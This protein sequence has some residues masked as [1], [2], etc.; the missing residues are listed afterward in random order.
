MVTTTTPLAQIVRDHP[1]AARVFHRYHLDFCC[2]GQHSLQDACA[3][4][5]IDAVNV[6]AEL[7]ATIGSD[8]FASIHPDMWSTEFLTNFILQN[9]HAFVRLELPQ[10]IEQMGKVVQKHGAKFVEAVAIL[11]LLNELHHT[12]T[13]HMMVEETDLLSYAA[14]STPPEQRRTIIEDHVQEH[15]DLGKKLQRLRAITMDFAPPAGA[16]TTHRA[17]YG[18]MKRFY[19]D[20]MQHVFLENSILFPRLAGTQLPIVQHF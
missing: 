19:E 17:A 12:L 7:E 5:H 1:A 3:E 13:H 15:E 10:I 16:C 8:A 20:T 2:G 9:H 4:Q 6:L 11:E 18:G 14:T